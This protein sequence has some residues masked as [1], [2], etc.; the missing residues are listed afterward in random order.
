[1]HSLYTDSFNP[2]LTIEY[3]R[4]NDSNRMHCFSCSALLFHRLVFHRNGSLH[5]RNIVFPKPDHALDP[6]GLLRGIRDRRHHHSPTHRPVHRGQN[7]A[8]ALASSNA[9]SAPHRVARAPAH[10]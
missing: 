10:R 6:G 4:D 2:L 1:M 5:N 3:S 9:L 7:Q 8:V